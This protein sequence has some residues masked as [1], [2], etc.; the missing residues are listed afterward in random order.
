MSIRI[1]V[2]AYRQADLEATDQRELED[3]RGWAADRFNEHIERHDNGEDAE[4]CRHCEYY[5]MLA[6]AADDLLRLEPEER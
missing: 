5:E 3:L 6:G 1:G 4:G 2:G